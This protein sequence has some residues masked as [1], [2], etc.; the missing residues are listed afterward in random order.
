MTRR[1]RQLASCVLTEVSIRPP[2]GC[3]LRVSEVSVPLAE[4]AASVSADHVFATTTCHTN[5]QLQVNAEK[6]VAGRRAKLGVDV[7][8]ANPWDFCGCNPTLY[9]PSGSGQ[10]V[11]GDTH[12]GSVCKYVSL[13]DVTSQHRNSMRTSDVIQV[14][15]LRS[16]L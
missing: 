12:R 1:R 10:L 6:Y 5:Q 15:Q 11:S 16:E 9:S 13:H 8:G 3:A 14:E 7:D 4:C 2:P